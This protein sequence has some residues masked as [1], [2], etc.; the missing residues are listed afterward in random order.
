MLR[1]SIIFFNSLLSCLS[2]ESIWPN[3]FWSWYLVTMFCPISPCT[4][5]SLTVYLDLCKMK[6][7]LIILST[8]STC[9]LWYMTKICWWKPDFVVWLHVGLVLNN[10]LNLSPT[11]IN[12]EL[13]FYWLN[14]ILIR[15]AGQTFQISTKRIIKNKSLIGYFNNNCHFGL[16]SKLYWLGI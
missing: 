8:F 5:H 4:I 12:N 14:L 3:W 2:I 9:V 1:F 6:P 10:G 7:F 13:W 16:T 15:V 11:I